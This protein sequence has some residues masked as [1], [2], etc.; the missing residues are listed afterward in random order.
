MEEKPVPL[1]I[2]IAGGTGSG[3]TTVANTVLERVGKHRITFLPHDA[4]YRDLSHLPLSE[5]AE[6]NFDHPDSLETELLVQL[7]FL[8][9]SIVMVYA[10]VLLNK[11]ILHLK[12]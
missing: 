12:L 11:Y 9:K 6:R 1:I 8:V 3:K 5:R 7:N 10:F 4:Y 2:G